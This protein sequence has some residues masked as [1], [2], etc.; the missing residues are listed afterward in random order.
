[1]QVDASLFKSNQVYSIYSILFFLTLPPQQ[2]QQQQQLSRCQDLATRLRGQ[3]IS[4]NFWCT[5]KYQ[6][7]VTNAQLPKK[8]RD[9]WVSKNVNNIKKAD[10]VNLSTKGVKILKIMS[11]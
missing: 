9:L 10:V 4:V 11:M 8:F 1:M 3:K 2:E 5:R 6:K 7:K